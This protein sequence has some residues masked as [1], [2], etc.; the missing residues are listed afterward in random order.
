MKLFVGLDVSLSK[1]SIC[2]IS[3]HG[4]IIKEAETENEGNLFVVKS[5]LR[6]RYTP[7]LPEMY[8]KFRTQLGPVSGVKTTV[9]N[10]RLL[11]PDRYSC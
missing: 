11:R 10:G 5:F 6:Y 4:K 9:R 3:E 2:V 7:L 1:T 8:P